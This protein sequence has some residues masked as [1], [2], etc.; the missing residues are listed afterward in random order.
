MDLNQELGIEK[1]RRNSSSITEK[2]TTNSTRERLPQTSVCC[3]G[4]LFSLSVYVVA[5]RAV[6]MR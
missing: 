2:K 3:F 1:N 4:S 6:S 5:T